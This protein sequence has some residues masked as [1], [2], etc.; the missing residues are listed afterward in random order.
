VTG[1]TK[2]STSTSSAPATVLFTTLFVCEIASRWW[3]CVWAH[4]GGGGVCVGWGRVKGGHGTLALQATP[5]FVGQTLPLA[6]AHR[7]SA[8]GWRRSYLATASNHSQ[9]PRAQCKRGRA[10]PWETPT[11]PPAGQL[12]QQ[13]TCQ[14]LPVPGPASGWD[15]LTSVLPVGHQSWP[16]DADNQNKA[17]ISLAGFM[18]NPSRIMVRS[19]LHC[20]TG[21][22]GISGLASG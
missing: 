5:T 6:T 21:I 7:L 13:P 11:A 9:A 8:P 10:L 3:W 12:R 4:C 22:T 2:H 20:I 17:S 1:T 15:T 16:R 18:S 14:P 19:T